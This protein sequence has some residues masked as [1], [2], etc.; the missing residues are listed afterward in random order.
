MFYL[1]CW[2]ARR[3]QPATAG[4]GPRGPRKTGTPFFVGYRH[5]EPPRSFVDAQRHHRARTEH[6]YLDPVLVVGLYQ[7]LISVH[8]RQPSLDEAR[9]YVLRITAV[10]PEEQIRAHLVGAADVPTS[11][12]EEVLPL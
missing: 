3:E 8:E 1:A 6:P 4:P 12:K 7:H 2:P 9:Q 11:P 5:A 10:V